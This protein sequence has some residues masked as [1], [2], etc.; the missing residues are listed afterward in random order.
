MSVRKNTREIAFHDA[1]VG[2]RICDLLRAQHCKT[3]VML[4]GFL[5]YGSGFLD[6]KL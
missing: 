4:S 6:P 5:V 1:R 3:T 2:T